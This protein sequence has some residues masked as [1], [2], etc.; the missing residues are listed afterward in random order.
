MTQVLAST[1]ARDRLPKLIE[2]L[3]EHPEDTVEVGRQR[4]REVVILAAERYDEMID[5]E[6]AVRDVMWTLF[7]EDRI[8]NPTSKPVS[9]EGAQ[10]RRRRG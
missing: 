8:A 7:A 9:W 10:R 4:R 3:V 5:R 1:E 6:E 2:Q